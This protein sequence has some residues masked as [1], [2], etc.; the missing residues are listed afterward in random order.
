MYTYACNSV[1]TYKTC[2]L[3]T[4]VDEFRS[5]N[6]DIRHLAGFVNQYSSITSAV[7]ALRACLKSMHCGTVKVRQNKGEVYL[8]K[9][10]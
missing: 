6:D 5:C 2:A 3:Q 4:I 8:M 10:Y 1:M 7:N 9:A